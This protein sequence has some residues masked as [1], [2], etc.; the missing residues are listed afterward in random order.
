MLEVKLNKSDVKAVET[1]LGGIN[2]PNTDSGALYKGMVDASAYMENKLKRAI[3][4]RLL[5]VRT[6]FLRNSI[7]SIVRRG[8][9]GTLEGLVGSGV[10]YGE[11][12]VYADILETGGTIKPKAGNKTGF[13]WI[14]IRSGS[15]MAYNMF[16]QVQVGSLRKAGFRVV[17]NQLKGKSFSS[18]VLSYIPVRS[19]TIPPKRWMSIPAQ[20]EAQNIVDLFVRRLG[21]Y[22]KENNVNS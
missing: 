20:E 4:G 12:A 13:L 10:R 2:P 19:V 21:K 1:M 6:G 9:D 8:T 17:G 22:I 11:R 5:K 16:S 15:D 7:G 3:S 18:K 14:P